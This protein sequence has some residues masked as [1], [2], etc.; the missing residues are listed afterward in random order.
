MRRDVP[1][2][3]FIARVITLTHALPMQQLALSLTAVCTTQNGFPCSCKWV[4]LRTWE[5]TQTWVSPYNTTRGTSNKRACVARFLNPTD[6]VPPLPFVLGVCQGRN[7]GGGHRTPPIG[8]CDGWPIERHRAGQEIAVRVPGQHGDAQGAA[9][10]EARNG[11]VRV[12]FSYQTGWWCFGGR[13]K[14]AGAFLKGKTGAL[15]PGPIPGLG[16]LAARCTK[17]KMDAMLSRI[18]FSGMESRVRGFDPEQ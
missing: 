18:P 11:F 17:R 3:M 6:F 5:S 8:C 7:N 13:V 4:C 10:G 1:F 2:F 15:P 14:T 9:R 16:D 12:V